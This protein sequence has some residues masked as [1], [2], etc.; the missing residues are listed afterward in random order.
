MEK[1]ATI[2]LLQMAV[3]ATNNH[4]VVQATF[5]S[6]CAD[7]CGFSRRI[8]RES[9]KWRPAV[10]LPWSAV[11]GKRSIPAKGRKVFGRRAGSHEPATVAERVSIA[12][13][14]RTN[15]VSVI[16]GR[17]RG[18]QKLEVVLQ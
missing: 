4:Y 12:H 6:S 11:D 8:G 14:D 17:Q 1:I 7:L 3:S 9:T 18:A 15:E 13:H 16:D 10:L 5:R 2:V